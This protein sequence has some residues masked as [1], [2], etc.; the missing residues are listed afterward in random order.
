MQLVD[1][2]GNEITRLTD[3][4]TNDESIARYGR[5]ELIL[6]RLRQTPSTAVGDRDTALAERGWPKTSPPSFQTGGPD[7]LEVEV[8]GYWATAFFKYLTVGNGQTDEFIS[9][10]IRDVVENN[11]DFLDVGVIRGNSDLARINPFDRERAGN[12]LKRLINMGDVG[13]VWRFIV[14]QSRLVRVEPID[15]KPLYF[16]RNRKFFNTASTERE[17]NPFQVQAG[18]VARDL[19]FPA[20][21][22]QLN[23]FLENSTDFVLEDVEVSADGDIQLTALDV[24]GL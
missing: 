17:V 13:T 21:K 23:A 24:G 5:R 4:A 2:Q 16:R 7:S 9:E 12:V 22:D 19:D 20:R 8:V 1:E 18:V 6:T 10:L 11:C 15:V 3:F 14:G